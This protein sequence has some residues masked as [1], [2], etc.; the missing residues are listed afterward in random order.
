M[1]ICSKEKQFNLLKNSRIASLCTAAYPDPTILIQNHNC[2]KRS[3]AAPIT[4]IDQSRLHRLEEFICLQLKKKPA[5]PRK[6]EG[7]RIRV[8]WH[9]EKKASPEQIIG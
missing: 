5:R 2:R 9:R 7:S 3:P 8:S 1:L 6:V 4:F